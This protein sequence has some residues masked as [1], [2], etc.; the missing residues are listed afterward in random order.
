MET[1]Q[2]TTSEKLGD[3]QE[4]NPETTWYKTDEASFSAA[5]KQYTGLSLCQTGGMRMTD[6]IARFI[7][8]L[9]E[10]YSKVRKHHG[11]DNA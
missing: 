10:I 3:D 9:V 5:N 6:L 1:A 8:A 7:V 2:N 11:G 4:I